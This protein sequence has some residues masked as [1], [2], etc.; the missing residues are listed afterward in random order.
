MEPVTVSEEKPNPVLDTD[1][2]KKNGKED[3][4]GDDITKMLEH[5]YQQSAPDDD[6]DDDDEEDSITMTKELLVF[7]D[8]A[9]NSSSQGV[10]K[11]SLSSLPEGLTIKSSTV[12]SDDGIFTRAVI[13]IGVC[14]G[15]FEGEILNDMEAPNRYSWEIHRDNRLHH[16]I[17]GQ[18]ESKAN[19]MRYVKCTSQLKR[20]NLVAFQYDEKIYFKTTKDIPHDTELMLQSRYVK[21]VV[22]CGEEV[23]CRFTY[24]GMKYVL[25]GYT[26]KSI[27]CDIC[28]IMFNWIEECNIHRQTHNLEGN[29]SFSNGALNAEACGL[30]NALLKN[31]QNEVHANMHN[32]VPELPIDVC[33]DMTNGLPIAAISEEN[34]RKGTVTEEDGSQRG[35]VTGMT[36][37][38]KPKR[39][40]CHLCDK[41]FRH[42]ST[43]QEHVMW[44]RGDKPFKCP[45]CSKSFTSVSKLNRHEKV[46]SGN[47]PYACTVCERRFIQASHLKSHLLI[48]TS[49]PSHQCNVC[50]KSYT[51]VSSLN[52]HMLIH[53]G[54]FPFVCSFC[55]DV[56]YTA[57][58]NEKHMRQHTGMKPYK[59]EVCGKGFCHPAN[60][61]KHVKLH[62]GENPHE[63]KICGKGFTQ[64]VNLEAH[65]RVH[66][67]EKPYQCSTCDKRFTTATALT[68][69]MKVHS[70]EI[71]KCPVCAE[72][73]IHSGNLK[74]HLAKS[75]G[76]YG[77]AENVFT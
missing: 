28:G 18:D 58:E 64:L 43:L 38:S 42:S 11:R 57:K 55:G 75:H 69:H 54:G 5:Y 62:M 47:R 41:S 53:K 74:R 21:H 36:R 37:A 56:L 12:G 29:T 32:G 23:K 17:S 48:H 45:D 13:P 61:T 70:G 8:S 52:R 63:C 1:A 19:W 73:F 51:V 15:P 65:V 7:L 16:Y 40:S 77:N 31:M 30:H 76:D 49:R 3:D 72:E 60:L 39:Y 44:H 27:T 26:Y 68:M 6:D 4:I 10:Q 20:Q 59:C 71:H 14:L 50:G 66:L 35:A 46:H 2:S 9:A 25:D 33:K 67:G 24:D 22:L 34:P